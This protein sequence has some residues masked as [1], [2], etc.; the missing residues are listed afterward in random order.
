MR[1]G[2]GRLLATILHHCVR[3][4]LFCSIL[5]SVLEVTGQRD[6]FAPHITSHYCIRVRETKREG[7]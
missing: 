5:S 4:L 2:A 3:M 1:L 6:T 7:L